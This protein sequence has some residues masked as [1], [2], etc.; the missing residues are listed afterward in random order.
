MHPQMAHDP[1]PTGL[2]EEIA[3]I[4]RLTVRLQSGERASRVEVEETL[5]AGFGTLVGLE[6]A[7]QR[8]RKRGGQAEVVNADRL[9]WAIGRLTEALAGLRALSSPSRPVRVGYGFVLPGH[10][11]PHSS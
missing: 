4:T 6:A 3:S 11:D 5:E 2:A 1:V 9:E 10:A 8:A 7:L